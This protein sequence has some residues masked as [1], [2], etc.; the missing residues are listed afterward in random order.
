MTAGRGA[1]P[2]SLERGTFL[3]CAE[4]VSSCEHARATI[5]IIEKA[6]NRRSI[7]VEPKNG[8]S[9]DERASDVP[10]YFASYT[11]FPPIQVEITRVASISESGTRMMSRSRTTKSAYLPGVSEPRIDSWNPA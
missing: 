7:D 4:A 6:K 3:V 1:T 11:R 2:S 9:L 5:E 8:R 10:R